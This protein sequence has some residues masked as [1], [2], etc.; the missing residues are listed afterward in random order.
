MEYM[1]L[2]R[3]LK[4]QYLQKIFLGYA[5]VKGSKTNT[6]SQAY[7]FIRFM[8]MIT[9]IIKT[10]ETSNLQGN[11]DILCPISKVLHSIINSTFKIIVF[12]CRNL[13]SIVK[14]FSPSMYQPLIQWARTKHYQRVNDRKVGN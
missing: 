8:L 1:L 2:Q 6:K 5:D 12:C 11:S 7:C 13:T 14:C 3:P 9:E 4:S 10:D